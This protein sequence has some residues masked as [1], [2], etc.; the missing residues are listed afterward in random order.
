MDYKYLCLQLVTCGGILLGLCVLSHVVSPPTS[1]PDIF[2]VLT[3]C[4][5][6]FL[7]MLTMMY[8]NYIQLT[9][10]EGVTNG[11]ANLWDATYQRSNIHLK[12]KTKKFH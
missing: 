8:F 2:P 1:L 10:P 5:S 3:S 4:Y 9:L 11:P 6:C 12:I 7:F